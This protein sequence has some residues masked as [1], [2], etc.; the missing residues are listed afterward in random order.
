MADIPYFKGASADDPEILPGVSR[1]VLAGFP[2]TLLITGTRD[3]LMSSEIDSLS[4]PT[5]A[6]V[7]AQLHVWNGMWHAFFVD[8]GMPESMQAYQV[9]ARFFARHLAPFSPDGGNGSLELLLILAPVA[10]VLL[11]PA[12]V[13]RAGR[14]NGR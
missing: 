9:I 3:F 8:P 11:A 5:R 14:Q 13:K 2:P 6:G 1:K 7:D 12:L 10:A 4:L